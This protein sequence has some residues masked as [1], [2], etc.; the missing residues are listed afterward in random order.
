MTTAIGKLL[1][2]RGFAKVI[3]TYQFDL[4][5][6]ILLPFALL[7]SLTELY[8]AIQI[9]RNNHPKLNAW[10]AILSHFGYTVLA[11]VTL[12]RGIQLQN[13]G[14]FGVFWAR[15][16]TNQTVVE[17]A[18]LLLIS[19]LFLLSLPETQKGISSSTGSGSK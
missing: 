7:I 19:V 15:P 11:I 2:N 9:F 18:T 1:D 16:M 17:D 12:S 5:K 3:E 14:C 10:F 8:F 4:P 13:C 6:A